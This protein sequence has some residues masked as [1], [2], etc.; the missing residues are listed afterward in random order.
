MFFVTEIFVASVF[1]YVLIDNYNQYH[2]PAGNAE[3][4]E[5]I[6]KRSNHHRISRDEESHSDVGGPYVMTTDIIFHRISR[7]TCDAVHSYVIIIHLL[8][9]SGDWCPA[10][11]KGVMDSD[12]I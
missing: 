1:P 2:A 11:S 12:E 4:V 10:K 8:T 6:E 7:T 5:N 3:N 9:N